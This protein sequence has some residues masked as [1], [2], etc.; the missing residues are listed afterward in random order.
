MAIKP[1]KGL[2]GHVAA[3]RTLALS[4]TTDNDQGLPSAVTMNNF[5]S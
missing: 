1:F 5:L 4:A 3:S 2:G